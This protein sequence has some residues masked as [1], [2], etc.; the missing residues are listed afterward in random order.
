[1]TPGGQSWE[2]AAL[3]H[4]CVEWTSIKY[5][6]GNS[7]KCTLEPITQYWSVCVSVCACMCV[8][9]LPVKA[10]WPGT[11]DGG[12]PACCF[13]SAVRLMS[14]LRFHSGSGISCA[15][16]WFET[17]SINSTFNY[18]SQTFPEARKKTLSY[19]LLKENYFPLLKSW[20]NIAYPYQFSV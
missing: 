10:R 14:I 15:D 9:A 1:M 19:A 4:S 8:Y 3:C 18:S 13:F 5:G 6:H 20:R 7:T 11:A 16:H 12:H 17:S 2:G